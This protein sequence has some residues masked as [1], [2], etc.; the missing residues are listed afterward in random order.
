MSYEEPDDRRLVR[1]YFLTQGRTE[2]QATIPVES[3]VRT[4]RRS[5]AADSLSQEQRAIVELCVD[6]IAVAEVSARLQLPLGVTRVLISDMAGSGLV[7]LSK[8]TSRLDDDFFDTMIAGVRRA[9]A[10]AS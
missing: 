4:V 8:P 10:L 7:E 6:P 9:A 3:I 2:P 1:P 5:R